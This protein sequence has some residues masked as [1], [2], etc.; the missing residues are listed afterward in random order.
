MELLLQRGAEPKHSGYFGDRRGDALLVVAK[1][2]HFKIC[3]LLLNHGAMDCWQMKARPGSALHAATMSRHKDV[4]HLMLLR[5][6]RHDTPHPSIIRP[7]AG[8]L[9]ASQYSA[10]TLGQ[11]DILR[12]LMS[13][14]VPRN[15]ALR[16]IA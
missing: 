14:G 13:Y 1:Q 7:G 16:Y 4:V 3:D 5:G 10:A 8:S 12:E 9:T 15:E 11:I 6:R 2:G